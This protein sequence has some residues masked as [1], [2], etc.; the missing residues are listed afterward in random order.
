MPHPRD[1]H[2]PR[3]PFTLGGHPYHVSP[4]GW[5]ALSAGRPPGAETLRQSRSITVACDM[6][7]PSHIDCSP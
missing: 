2:G 7:P 6:P 5:L 4:E 3:A 1:A